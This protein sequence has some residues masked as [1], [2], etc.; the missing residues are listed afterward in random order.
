L[1]CRSPRFLEPESGTK[2]V[3]GDLLLAVLKNIGVEVSR[4]V[5]SGRLNN[6]YGDCCRQ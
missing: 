3:M 1:P 4:V 6:R 2:A 5:G